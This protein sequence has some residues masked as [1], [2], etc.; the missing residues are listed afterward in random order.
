MGP[1]PEQRSLTVEELRWIERLRKT[2]RAKPESL[3]LMTGPACA[4]VFAD[5]DGEPQNPPHETLLAHGLDTWGGPPG[6]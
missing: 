3:W 2:I 6:K 1:T 5:V 4:F